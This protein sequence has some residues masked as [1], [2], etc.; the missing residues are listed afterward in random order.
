MRINSFPGCCTAV[1]L[2]EFGESSV[3]EGGPKKITKEEVKEYIEKQMK[4]YKHVGHA[5]VVITTNNQ[6]II[7]N[8]VLLEL[9]F[10]KSRW[11]SKK[12]HPG[13]KVRL[14]HKALND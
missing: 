3:A 5:M 13:T 7:T 1:I 14:W 4:V 11:M 2:S 9:G 8:S 12:Q 6:Q 10:S